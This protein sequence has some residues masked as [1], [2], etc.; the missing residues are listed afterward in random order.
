MLPD[1]TGDARWAVP[2]VKTDGF[3]ARN[4]KE[5]EAFMR[6]DLRAS[7]LAPEQVRAYVNDIMPLGKGAKGGYFLPYFD[8]EGH[9]MRHQGELTMYRVKQWGGEHKYS[10]PHRDQ[11]VTLDI[12]VN[13]PYILPA[14]HDLMKDSKR[15]VICEGEKKA[16]ATIN[17]L[18]LGAIGIGGCWNWGSNKKLHPWIK[19]LINRYDIELV[20]VIPDGDIKRYNICT[21]YG[22]L[23]DQLRLLGVQVELLVLPDTEDKI[24]DLLVEWGI[25][26]EAMFDTLGKLSAGELVVSQHVLAEQYGLSVQG[27]NSTVVVNDSNV[28]K[29]LEDHPAFGRFWLNEDTNTYYHGEDEIQW[30]DTDHQLTSYM[31]HYFQLHNLNRPRV[32]DAMRYLCH[33]NK[34]SPFRDWID[35][36][37]WDGT[38]RLEDWAIRLWGCAD[39]ATTREVA[40]KFLVGMYARMST[41]GCKMDWMLVTVG[42]QGVG[43]SWWADLMTKGQ[44]ISFMA[45]GN[46]RDDAAKIHRGLI[47]LIDEMD[48]FNKREMTY[49]KTMITTHVDTYRAPYARG[50]VTM[51]RR[52]VLYGTSNHRTFLR[53]D[54]TGQ[55]RFGVLEPTT[56]LL[57]KEFK[58]ELG[59]L[60]AEAKQ[61]FEN[62]DC[63]YF[64]LS[65]EIQLEMAEQHQSEDPMQM[66][67]QEFL[68]QL[69]PYPNAP[70]NTEERRFRMMDLLTYMEMTNMVQ[71]RSVTGPLKDMLLSV[72]CTYKSMLRI[73]K[74][75]SAGYTYIPA[76][77]S[78]VGGKY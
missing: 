10:Q 67:V 9:I 61:V 68:N 40:S 75:A 16:A 8:L 47:I 48:A 23:A 44:S 33:Q 12:P 37:Q 18:G 69:L 19:E 15:L 6:K 60:W 49:W 7:G 46:A 45:S 29:L 20:T 65:R 27:K 1:L 22:T 30:D 5:A 3:L 74:S 53:H 77:G 34:V 66:K 11:L 31:Q 76:E 21:A 58:A 50:E 62:G 17:Q 51:R 59:Q 78:A 72:G 57:V 14:A 70:G 13:V 4:V 43:K 55:R 36:Q 56:M 71:A 54:S 24:D 38:S 41:P 39:N 32:A 52:S 25:E 2:I 73:G 63:A 42:A 26:A 35:A 64:E 28:T